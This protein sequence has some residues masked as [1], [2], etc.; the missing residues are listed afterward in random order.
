[1]VPLAGAGGKTGVDFPAHL[2]YGDFR[3]KGSS[4]SVQGQHAGV[5]APGLAVGVKKP[6]SE[7]FSVIADHTKVSLFFLGGRSNV[8]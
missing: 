6:I 1:M 5:R 4:Y 7:T 2:G 3:L 8:S